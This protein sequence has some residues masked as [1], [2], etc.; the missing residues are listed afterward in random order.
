MIDNKKN[1]KLNRNQKKALNVLKSKNNIFLTGDPGVGKTYLINLFIDELKKSNCN[2]LVTASTGIAALNLGGITMHK[3]FSI[4]IPAYGHPVKTSSYTFLQYVDVVIIEEISLCRNDAFSYMCNCIKMAEKKFN[5]KIQL[6]IIGDFYQLPP[7]VKQS[8]Y[9]KMR[10]YGYDL[11]GYAFTSIEWKTMKFKIIA[12]HE[13]IRQSDVE[14]INN[15]NKLKVSN[16]TC[17]KYFNKKVQPNKEFYPEN[18]VCLCSTNVAANAINKEKLD[19]IDSEQFIYLAEKTG[20]ISTDIP[21]DEVVVLKNGAK[22]I[23]LNNDNEHNNYYNGMLGTVKECKKNGAIIETE[24][25]KL[26]KVEPYIWNIYTYKSRNG[27]IK[28]EIVGT[29]KQMPVRLAYAITIHKSQGKTFEKIILDPKAFADGQLYVALSRL[30]S[31]D[32]LY[33]TEEIKAEYLKTNKKVKDFYE[34]YSYTVSEA[35]TKKQK[36][37]NKKLNAPKKKSKVRSKSNNKS[38]TKSKLHLSKSKPKVK[39]QKKTRKQ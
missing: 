3:A 13:V 32:G 7:V 16:K 22:I 34:N 9:N 28:K 6:I 15:L 17:I 37:Y 23:F 39:K 20:N 25:G 19:S 33:L 36:D 1:N 38:K 27:I 21:N 2:V 35:Q 12:L 18:A 31:I 29:F 24:Q 14:F 10:T 11:S 26:I 4:P 5:K 30:K 8:E